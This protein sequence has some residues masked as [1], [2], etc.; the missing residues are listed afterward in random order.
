M[1]GGFRSVLFVKHV[2]RWMSKIGAMHV[3][4][5]AGMIPVHNATT[6]YELPIVVYDQCTVRCFLLRD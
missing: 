1:I 2:E 3:A 4:L 5:N 6:Q